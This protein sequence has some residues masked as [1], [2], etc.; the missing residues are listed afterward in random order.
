MKQIK[1]F[2]TTLIFL[3]IFSQASAQLRLGAGMGFGFDTEEFSIFARAAYDFSE[4]WRANATYNYFFIG[5]DEL[6]GLNI[7]L[8][9]LNFDVH[10]TFVKF[11]T[12]D[13]YGLGGV[14]IAT[15]KVKGGESDTEVGANLGVGSNLGVADKLD[16]VT[17]LKYT[18]GSLDQ[19]YFGAGL[20]FTISGR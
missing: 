14:N 15:S 10:Y 17:E 9:D 13:L 6:T 2:L 7:N 1:Y 4:E 18:V 11:L 3:S 16:I 8:S 5:E 20:L 12:I 19:F